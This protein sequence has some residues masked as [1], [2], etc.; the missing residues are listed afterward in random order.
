MLRLFFILSLFAIVS[1]NCLAQQPSQVSEYMIS[2]GM[3]SAYK[4]QQIT[5]PSDT[6][7]LPTKQN[8]SDDDKRIIEKAKRLSSNESLLSMLMLEK[9]QVIFEY[10][11]DPA[12]EN[13]PYFSF[14]MSKSL[15]AY[16]IGGMYCAK[17][18]GSLTDAGAIYASELKGTAMGE[19]QI[20]H[21]LTMSSG[22]KDA[23][24][25]DEQKVDGWGL[26][27]LQ[28]LSVVDYLQEYGVRGKG[29]FGGPLTSGSNFHY[30]STDPLSLT[31]I[32]ENTGGFFNNFKS[33]VW[34]LSG[35]ESDSFWLIDKNGFPISNGGF[36]ANL[37]DWGR[38]AILSINQQ[39]SKDECIS[40]FMR[41]ATK[42]QINNSIKRVLPEFKSYGYQTWIGDFGGAKSYWW[43]G[44]G[45]QRVG[46]DPV[47]ERV[48]IVFSKK[49]D[50]MSDVTDLFSYWMR[51]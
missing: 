28:Y 34:N 32:A 12:T 4:N 48:L 2:G 51:N 44:Y 19:A 17:K 5:K 25:S 18:I 49:S 7:P 46:I 21:L 16:T 26:M 50:Y 3:A 31:L 13:K 33:Y 20:K 14:S 23:F 40:N 9:G 11:K 15:V 22:V 36:S 45:G 8:L 29:F 30:S 37:R 41:D 24:F 43:A 38:L 42:R 1:Q 27:R 39:K 10:Y 47:S 35:A 6:L